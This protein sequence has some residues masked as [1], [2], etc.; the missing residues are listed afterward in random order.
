[1]QCKFSY[2][3]ER[4]ITVSDEGEIQFWYPPEPEEVAKTKSFINNKGEMLSLVPDDGVGWQKNKKV[5][6]YCEYYQLW[7]G[8]EDPSTSFC[9]AIRR[10][11]VSGEAKLETIR[12]SINPRGMSD[13]DFWVEQ[14]KSYVPDSLVAD[15]VANSD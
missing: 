2:D 15:Y 10:C 8:E 11:S 1:M 13:A 9:W 4:A 6:K 12:A 7:M 5:A 3:Q 14:C